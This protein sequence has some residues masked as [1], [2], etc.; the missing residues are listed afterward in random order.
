MNNYSICYAAMAVISD[1]V[2]KVGIQSLGINQD[3]FDKTTGEAVWMS[4]DRPVATRT[5]QQLCYGVMDAQNVPRIDLPAEYLAGIIALYVSPVNRF[6]ACG[7]SA[8]E[9]LSVD[10]ASRN[11]APERFD[12]SR[13]FALVLLAS[14]KD[15][16]QFCSHLTKATDKKLE[17]AIDDPGAQKKGG[18]K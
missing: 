2:K 18:A 8:G 3:D 12:A 1:T 14:S 4:A 6:A 16:T 5:I 17:Q 10:L 9:M 11:E 13:L 15:L 7:W